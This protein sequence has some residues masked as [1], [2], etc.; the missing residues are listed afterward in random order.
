[1]ETF[2][3]REPIKCVTIVSMCTQGGS[4][5]FPALFQFLNFDGSVLQIVISCCYNNDIKQM[6]NHC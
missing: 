4:Q 6:C 5:W 1:M 2:V 3:G